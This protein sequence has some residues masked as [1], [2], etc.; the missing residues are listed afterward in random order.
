MMTMMITISTS[1]ATAVGTAI[2]TARLLSTCTATVKQ[3]KRKCSLNS[4]KYMLICPSASLYIYPSICLLLAI[5]THK[6]HA[7][8]PVYVVYFDQLYDWSEM[9]VPQ[10]EGLF[11]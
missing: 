2:I 5:N 11:L 7:N 3:C 4:V 8:N 10:G 1:A 9:E 6:H